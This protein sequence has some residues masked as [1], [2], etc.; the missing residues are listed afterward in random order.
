MRMKIIFVYFFSSFFLSAQAQ[1]FNSAM[2]QQPNKLRL[3]AGTGGGAGCSEGNGSQARVTRPGGM[4]VDKDGNLYFSCNNAI[5]KATPGGNV[6]IIAGVAELDG[7]VD[8]NGKSARFSN[9]RGLAVDSHGNIFVSQYYS[10]IRKITPAG[11]VTTFAGRVGVNAIVDGPLEEA[12]FGTLWSMAIDKNDNIYV[13]ELSHH[14]IRKITPQGTV[15]TLAGLVGSAGAVDGVGSVARFRSPYGI[16]VDKNDNLYVADS[17]NHSIRKITLDGEVSTL[18]GRNGVSGNANGAGITARFNSPDGVSVDSEGNLYV[19]D[20]MNHTVRK[21]SETGLVTTVAGMPGTLGSQN[22]IGNTARFNQ[23]RAIAF[24]GSSSVYVSDSNNYLIRSVSAEGN[25]S[26]FVGRAIERGNVDGLHSEARFNNVFGITV[27]NDGNL[28]VADAGNHTIRKISENG[29]VTTFAGLAGSSGQVDGSGAAARFNSPR[30]VTID[31]SGNLY[32]ADYSGHTIRKVMPT[33]DVTT[34]AGTPG[35]SGLVD[36]PAG[37][38]KFKNPAD[39][40]FDSEGNLYVT[41]FS[42]HTIRKISPNGEVTT[43]A[44][45]GIL[46]STNGTGSA[47][48]F[49]QP[50]GITIDR[51]GDLFVVD[52]SNALIRKVTPAGTVSTVHSGS[53]YY[54]YS[55]IAAGEGDDLYIVTQGH[56]LLKSSANSSG[57]RTIRTIAGNGECAA[58][59]DSFLPTKIC[60]PLRVAVKNKKVYFST[61][62]SVWS[63]DI[64]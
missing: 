36:G 53:T 4:T 63:F 39:L 6:S 54:P 44:G 56:L 25:V 57:S 28:F 8:G 3:V 29:V 7:T 30:G 23:P 38:A 17:G 18:A 55:G 13:T 14:I 35:V 45:N 48:R 1:F 32:V 50:S 24:Y 61:A 10:V 11:D 47:A 12:R 20:A 33:G 26:T 64:P 16:A 19:A 49:Y 58:L 62:E 22:G 31:T 46:G 15:S 5:L 34:F 43:L 60:S 51:K 2:F 59:P 9:P 40:V 27:D 21:V 52:Q 42:G 41:E 37:Q